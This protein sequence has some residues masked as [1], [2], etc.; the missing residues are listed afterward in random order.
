LSES[1]EH[2]FRPIYQ[3]AKFESVSLV[4]IGMFNLTDIDECSLGVSDCSQLCV[5]TAGGYN[6]SCYSGY[7]ADGSNCLQTSKS[8]ISVAY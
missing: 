6:C 2:L 7:I 3:V 5:N 4:D 8:V 1:V